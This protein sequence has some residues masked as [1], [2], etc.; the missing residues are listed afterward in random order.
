MAGNDDFDL[1]DIDIDS[2][3]FGDDGDMP[4]GPS[5]RTPVTRVASSFSKAAKETVKSPSFFARTLKQAL[6]E[7]Y[8]AAIDAADS[9][10]SAVGDLY[11]EADKDLSPA[12]KMAR[13]QLRKALPFAEKMLP[14]S[15]AKKLQDLAA[16]EPGSAAKTVDQVREE[17]I[18]LRMGEVFD[19]YRQEMEANTEQNQ[20]EAKV[21][22]RLDEAKHKDQMS[23]LVAMKNHT[24]RMVSFQDKVDYGYKR[25]ML[26][27]GY[28]QLYTQKDS[29]EQLRATD[30][31]TREALEAIRHNTSLPDAIKIRGS[32]AFQAQLRSRVIEGIQTKAI[33]SFAGLFDNVKKNSK[34]M[35]QG[36]TERVNSAAEASEMM[37]DA[38][39]MGVDRTDLA[40]SAGVG[41]GAEMLGGK[42]ANWLNQQANRSRFIRAMNH[43]IYSFLNSA[44]NAVQDWSETPEEIG[45]DDSLLTKGKKL[46]KN[47]LRTL[48]SNPTKIDQIKVATDAKALDQKVDFNYQTRRTINEVI[49]G[50]LARILREAVVARTGNDNIELDRYDFVKGSFIGD[51]LQS[52]MTRD[53]VLSNRTVG[54]VQVDLDRIMG[55][56]DPTGQ[57]SPGDRKIIEKTLIERARRGRLSFQDGQAGSSKFYSSNDVEANQRIASHMSGILGLDRSK[58]DRIFDESISKRSRDL[59]R[60]VNGLGTS[61]PSIAEEIANQ[62]LQGNTEHLVNAGLIRIDGKNISINEEQ[63]VKTLMHRNSMQGG[64]GP[65]GSGPSGGGGFSPWD[66]KWGPTGFSPRFVKGKQLPTSYRYYGMQD[67]NMQGGGLLDVGRG[68]ADS[69]KDYLKSNFEFLRNSKA[70]RKVEGGVNAASAKVQNTTQYKQAE[71]AVTQ[72][73]NKVASGEVVDVEKVMATVKDPEARKAAVEAVYTNVTDPEVRRQV[74]DSAEKFIKNPE[75]RQR[76]LMR[77]QK[78]AGGLA[79]QVADT[80]TDRLSASTAHGQAMDRILGNDVRRDPRYQAMRA[81]YASQEL[82]QRS[83]SAAQ[84][85]K[86]QVQQKVSPEG[87]KQLQEQFKEIGSGITKR[88]SAA[89]LAAGDYYDTISGKT[90]QSLDDV[91]GEVRDRKDKVVLSLR[92]SQRLQNAV[93]RLRGMG[94]TAKDLM[95]FNRAHKAG[96]GQ[97]VGPMPY[98][99]RADANTPDAVSVIRDAVMDIREMLASGVGIDV[100]KD[101]KG[102]GGRILGGLGSGIGGV[103]SGAGKFYKGAFGGMGSV[104]GGAGGL[105]G[106]VLG[107]IGNRIRGAGARAGLVVTDIYTKGAPEPVI[108]AKGLRR[109]WY[110]DYET[111]EPI[112]SLDDIDGAVWDNHNEEVALTTD[113]FNEGI[114]Y[115]KGESLIKKAGS[116]LIDFYGAMFS[117]LT[118]AA[119]IA[120]MAMRGAVGFATRVKDIYVIGERS[121]RL[122]SKVLINGGYYSQRTNQPIRKYSDID[123]PVIDGSGDVVLDWSDIK[124]GLVGSDGK[125]IRGLTE[126]LWNLAKKPFEIAWGIGKGAFKVAGAVI[127]GVGKGIGAVGRKL[128]GGKKSAAGGDI[129]LEAASVDI[130][131]QIRDLLDQRLPGKGSPWDSDGDG[132]RDGGW[133]DRLAARKAAND[134]PSGRDP[135]LDQ[136]KDKSG[137]GLWD[138]L[139][140]MI[141]GMGGDDDDGGWDIDVGGDGWGDSESRDKKRRR[142]QAKKR[143]KRMKGKRGLFRRA[144]DGAR[145]LKGRIFKK[146]AS[147]AGRTVAG[148]IARKA[149]TRA[150][151]GTGLRM[152]A[153]G[154]A[155]AG[156]TALGGVAAGV[157]AV[158]ASPVVVIGGAIAGAAW[159]G[160]S[161]WD[162]LRDKHLMRM[163]MAMYGVNPD[164]E[165]NEDFMDMIAYL[166]DE[167]ID[168]VQ[169]ASDGTAVIAPPD[170]LEDI[171]D[172]FDID[173]DNQMQVDTFMSW[174]NNRFKPVF[175]S[176]VAANKAIAPNVDFDDLDGDLEDKQ[177]VAMAKRV[178]PASSGASDPIYQQT[179]SP[180]PDKG[181][182]DASYGTVVQ[183]K[184]EIISEFSSP[185]EEKKA[186]EDQRSKRMLANMMERSD[187]EH[188]ATMEAYRASKG[189]SPNTQAAVKAAASSIAP[190]MGGGS[191]LNV[192]GTAVKQLETKTLGVLDAI[193]FKTYG[194]TELDI[195]KVRTLQ[196]LEDYIADYITYDG[197]GIAKYTQTAE[198]AAMSFADAFGISSS[199]EEG[200]IAW[201]VWFTMR[202]LPTFLNYATAVNKIDNTIPLDKADKLLD[203]SQKLEVATAIF[204]ARASS[205]GTDVSV[206][207]VDRSPWPGYAMNLNANSIRPNVAGLQSQVKTNTFGD[208]VGDVKD[209]APTPYAPGM[210]GN[211]RNAANDNAYGITGNTKGNPFV[212]TMRQVARETYKDQQSGS[213]PGSTSGTFIM[214]AQGRISSVFGPRIHPIT[215]EK[216]KMHKGIDIAAPAGTKVF[217]A[218]DGVI[219]R[220]EYSQSYGNVIYIKH[221]DGKTTR[222]A[223]MHGFAPGFKVGDTVRQG[224]LIG[225]VG[226]TGKSAGNHLHFEIRKTPAWDSDVIDPIKAIT[227]PD[228]KEMLSNLTVEKKA[229]KDE[230]KEDTYGDLEGVDT[231]ESQTTGESKE[232]KQEAVQEYKQADTTASTSSAMTLGPSS[233][234]K[235]QSAVSQVE[236]QKA[237][238]AKANQKAM[239][240]IA[241][242]LSE[243]LN[244]QRNMDGSLTSIRDDIRSMR[245]ATLAA[246]EAARKQRTSRTSPAPSNPVS[247]SKN[248]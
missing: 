197:N 170:D 210:S 55:V 243:S 119:K 104:L 38:A 126:R 140:G 108:L 86:D 204:T 31:Y 9:A 99:P 43:R 221:A 173:P 64:R 134:D 203:N 206:W 226:N 53:S 184:D 25:K 16:D 228:A 5:G 146:G 124:K 156:L 92:D 60:A 141:P 195:P 202:F 150:A 90:L 148:N 186:Q 222:Y 236:A 116:K 143:L 52:K 205:G 49:P 130:L 63:V 118:M 28:K 190:R 80:I 139:K 179:Q 88:L 187:R 79:S 147:T 229:A 51:K 4:N 66:P 201:I 241:A 214:P 114:F 131:T 59:S 211:T 157:G 152:A 212:N 217:A 135:R 180:F 27:L 58:K 107:G 244:V 77:A 65:R 128:F 72:I 115:Y 160:Y 125:P 178:C 48:I 232:D 109:G 83:G 153:T 94:S 110:T 122:L 196:A 47:F 175:A 6:P 29:L 7:G 85:I 194:L 168:G 149:A 24:A 2:F 161:I 37:E 171:L 193:R 120:T 158:L 73:A 74:V 68:Y 129:P 227:G 151:V 238:L 35:L 91:Q 219:T 81:Q 39:D 19:G 112:H 169:I 183:L 78:K 3:D 36:F 164:N 12:K 50:Y 1:D 132:D 220:R 200:S 70:G 106:G 224:Q 216:G 62:M 40:A 20:K 117:P 234:T 22:L 61:M 163:R 8:R 54:N 209:G 105:V 166:E 21:R 123:G 155:A 26:E 75:E 18:A 87:R 182:L 177:K 188:A 230:G 137:G 145:N 189:K 45:M 218:A 102:I 223:H 208:P 240:D 246:N 44:P 199:D 69:A 192:S 215:G 239:A 84:S 233:M 82:K 185:E 23:A 41:M 167:L 14:A 237:V 30:K 34:A 11:N 101:S 17:S 162:A 176:W 133:R 144:L 98:T 235:K 245:E 198:L 97:F 172:E 67:V 154:A 225:F 10:G 96:G 76:V 113:Q 100:T 207:G 165:D 103:L 191:K 159:L 213:V 127:G 32:E 57:L 13:K 121:P 93:S 248:R 46:G 174:M 138:F 231:I 111:G 95:G 247:M 42:A 181:Q 15:L 89:R 71:K 136:K 56:I 142:K 33:G 242:V